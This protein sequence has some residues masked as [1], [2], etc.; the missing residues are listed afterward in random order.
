M[1]EQHPPRN[2]AER[3]AAARGRGRRAAGA[4]LT[5]GSAALAMTAGV[6]G[7]APA[8]HAAGT[9]TVTAATDDGTGDPGT[10]SEAINSANGDPNS[11]I[12]FNGADGNV[13]I[14]GTMPT[15]TAP[16]KHIWVSRALRSM[17]GRTSLQWT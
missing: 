13:S 12:N 10:L 11:T 2:R 17:A 9:Y 4:A 7:S 8:A 15:I 1:I 5:A 3:R 6:I 14:T 16:L